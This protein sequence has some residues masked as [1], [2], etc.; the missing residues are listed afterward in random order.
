MVCNQLNS[1]ELV[2]ANCGNVFCQCCSCDD[3]GTTTHNYESVS[4]I[5]PV[6]EL[7][8]NRQFYS[9]SNGNMDTDEGGDTLIFGVGD[10]D[11]LMNAPVP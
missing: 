3:T 9:F 4:N 8:F 6:W 7:G 10:D 11:V 5:H 2:I 1:I